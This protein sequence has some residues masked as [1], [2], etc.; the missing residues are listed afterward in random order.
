MIFSK[1]LDAIC[2][3]GTGNSNIDWLLGAENAIEESWA[4]LLS[5]MKL[6][7]KKVNIEYCG[8]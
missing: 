4:R 6:I 2:L 8:I 5:D 3:S 7:T 1:E